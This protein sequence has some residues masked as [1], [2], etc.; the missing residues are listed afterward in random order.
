MSCASARAKFP[1]P[2]MKSA[3][4]QV[5]HNRA[6]LKQVLK[7]QSFSPTCQP[8]RPKQLFY[9]H[10]E[11]ILHVPPKTKQEDIK[12]ACSKVRQSQMR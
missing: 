8:K 6:F 3:T 4:T 11:H 7:N 1:V 12:L 9:T 10:H 5:V 2:T